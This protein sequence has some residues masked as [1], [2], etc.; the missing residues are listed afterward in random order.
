M[1]NKPED[2]DCF[3]NRAQDALGEAG[4][5]Y[6]LDG[7]PKRFTGRDQYPEVAPTPLT[8]QSPEHG[9]SPERDRVE[10]ITSM[11]FGQDLTKLPGAGPPPEVPLAPPPE[12]SEEAPS[13]P[14]GASSV[15]H[16]NVKRNGNL[17]SAYAGRGMSRE[18][19]GDFPTYELALAAANKAVR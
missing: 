3:F 18:H 1:Y 6:A 13:C 8:S 11:Q 2:R 5:R 16:P 7:P 14:S 12:T 19:L 15:F 4:G 9:F 10:E 17:W